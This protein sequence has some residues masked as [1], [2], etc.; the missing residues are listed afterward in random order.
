MLNPWVGHI[1]L[2]IYAI[3]LA[4]GGVMGFVRAKSHASLISGLLSALAAL[5]ALVLAYLKNPFGIPLGA[6]LAM[7]LF[8]VFGYRYA[9]R[10]RKFMP[11]GM[12]AVLSLI[13][14]GVMILVS[15]W[16]G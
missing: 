12:L 11:S 14:L 16:L 5:V 8:V 2:G 6:L 3:L 13:V 9:I 10:N 7:V 1:T 15:D 4:V